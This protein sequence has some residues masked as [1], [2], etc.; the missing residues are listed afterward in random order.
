MRPLCLLFLV[1]L[2]VGCAAPGPAATSAPNTSAANPTPAANPSATLPPVPT[3]PAPAAGELRLWHTFSGPARAALEALAAEF[4][5]ANP[6]GIQI[7]PETRANTLQLGQD[8]TRALTEG[9]WPPLV[10]GT[11]AQVS[12]WQAAGLVVPLED[13][14]LD[15][16]YGLTAAQNAALFWQPATTSPESSFLRLGLP[17]I[18]SAE[19]LFYNVAWAA[20]LGFTA[21]PANP[22]E[23]QQQACAAA[24]ANGDGTGG[25]AIS[26]D[27]SVTLA[28]LRAFGAAE[29]AGEGYAFDT[30]ETRAAFSFLRGLVTAGCAWQPGT[31]YPNAEFANR[32]ALFISANSLSI[33]AQAELLAAADWQVIAYPCEGANCQPALPLHGLE[34]ALLDAPLETQVAAWTFLHYFLQPEQQ[35]GWQAAS[36]SLPLSAESPAPLLTQTREAL[37][38]AR[39]YGQPEPARPSWTIVR[40]VLADAAR[41][42][43]SPG[44]TDLALR[45]LLPELQATVQE[46]DAAAGR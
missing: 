25:W 46:V 8:M 6:H 2:L 21:P 45:D 19:V 39:A 24:A 9:N 34:F 13:F 18:L 41:L 20:E 12:A 27:A 44:L 30:V 31:A 33:P 40:G 7:I 37:E 43:Y 11:P 42:L 23:F 3:L 22:A 29:L 4:N 26:T 28:W 10:I 16:A 17:A 32:Q 14:V 35:S 36:N 15:P 5:A 38:L 1:L